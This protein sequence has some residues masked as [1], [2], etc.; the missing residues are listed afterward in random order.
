M[1][2]VHNKLNQKTVLIAE[3]DPSTLKWLSKVLKIYFKEVY[4]ASDAMEAMDIFEQNPT[5]I[6]IADIQ[7]PTVDGLSFLQ[8]ISSMSPST[9]RVVMTAFNKE[10]YLN[11]AV[12]SNI[13][14][15]FKKPIDI[16]ELL[17]SIASNLPSTKE[18]T[19]TKLNHGYV[20]NWQNKYVQKEND[21]IKLTKKE[22]LLLELFINNA[23]S[24]ISL[25]Y[26]ENQI[27]EEPVTLDAIRMIIVGLR[28]KLSSDCIE[29]IKGL[30]YR[31]NL[32]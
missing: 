5:D 32:N 27:W 19:H 10:E 13:H 4:S 17:V 24:I 11:K 15:Y 7:M 3:D 1:N 16:D 8:R 23:N 21:I 31:L 6:V 22:V 30:G 26:I 18:Q 25:E 14:F 29:N 9:L 2:A 12:D 20:Y 28:K